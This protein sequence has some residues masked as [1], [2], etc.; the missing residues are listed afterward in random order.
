MAGTIL[1]LK[2]STVAS[3]VTNPDGGVSVRFGP[4]MIVKSEGI[5]QVD[6]STLWTQPGA[7]VIGEA[8]IEGELPELPARLDGG[9]M[10]AA[11]LKYVGM[12]SVPLDS[13]GYAQLK[14]DFERGAH[15]VVTGVN[16]RLE[17]EGTPK[18]VK[19][20]EETQPPG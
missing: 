8:E 9:S 13:L 15:M 12:S 1:L 7:L 2:G 20:I 16:A 17:M 11:G 5:P 4:A 14:L 18:Y 10:E 6:A 3:I 19:H